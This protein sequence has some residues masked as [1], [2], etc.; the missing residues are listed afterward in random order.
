MLSNVEKG[1]DELFS[2]M[3]MSAL[4][5]NIVQHSHSVS[6]SIFILKAITRVYRQV[7]NKNCNFNLNRVLNSISLFSLK[8]N[9]FNNISVKSIPN[10]EVIIIKLFAEILLKTTC[11]RAQIIC[12]ILNCIF[13]WPHIEPKE[14]P[15]AICINP[16][17]LKEI[18]RK[19]WFGW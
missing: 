4:T 9:K 18:I 19:V 17:C 2:N 15:S 6:H 16:S 1:N 12:S 11:Q 13:W 7:K 8:W 14:C 3:A 5:I 10:Y